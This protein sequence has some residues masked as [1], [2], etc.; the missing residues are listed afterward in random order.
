[1]MASGWKDQLVDMSRMP[2]AGTT[3][4]RGKRTERQPAPATAP[5]FTLLLRDPEK[6]ELGWSCVAGAS[7]S[8]HPPT[9]GCNFQL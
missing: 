8:R 9:C 5:G 6:L 1:L 4:C 7:F 2:G 3:L